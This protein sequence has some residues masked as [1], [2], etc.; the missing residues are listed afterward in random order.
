MI[1]ICTTNVFIFKKQNF[2]EASSASSA[3]TVYFPDLETR[4][5]CLWSARCADCVKNLLHIIT[6]WQHLKAARYVG[7]PQ[8][9]RRALPGR[10]AFTQLFT[11]FTLIKKQNTTPSFY[12]VTTHTSTHIRLVSYSSIFCFYMTEKPH[13]PKLLMFSAV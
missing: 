13:E 12:S 4:F 1:H 8:P 2:M 5:A 11:V 3:P 6:S 9:L 10:S 7:Y